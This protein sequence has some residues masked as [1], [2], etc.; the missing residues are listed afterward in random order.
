MTET[1]KDSY[2]YFWLCVLHVLIIGSLSSPVFSQEDRMVVERI[3]V[4]N[5]NL[6]VFNVFV[7]ED[8][9]KW[10]ANSKTVYKVLAKDVAEPA[11]LAPGQQSLLQLPGGN[12]D[13]RWSRD[14]MKAI[15]GDAKV[16]AAAYEKQGN[17]LWIGTDGYGVFKLSVNGGLKL[18][19]EIYVDNSKLRSDFI[20]S[21]YL[22]PDGKLWIATEDGALV[23]KKGGWDHVQRYF[24]IERIAGDRRQTWA[25]GDDL[26]WIID[27]NDNWEPIEINKREIEG[28]MHDIALDGEGNLWIASNIITRYHIG[29]GRY[30]HF[31][32]GQYFTSQFVNYV[33]VDDDGTIW[34]GTDDKGVYIIIKEST[35]TVTTNLD[36]PVSCDGDAANGA[37]SARIVGGFPPYSIAW[38]G[39]QSGDR[40]EGLSPGMYTVT[41][42]DS[43]GSSNTA[44]L[45][46][47]DPR[48]TIS[49]RQDQEESD[50]NA[51]D[52]VVSIEVDG[53]VPGYQASWSHGASGAKITGLTSG[54]YSVTVTDQAGCTAEADIQVTRTVRPLSIAIDVQTPVRCEES[55]DGIIAARAE[56]GVKPYTFRWS[57]GTDSSDVVK[58]LGPGQYA[59]TVTDK[60]G[61]SASASTTIEPPSGIKLSYAMEKAASTN[62]AD[63]VVTASASGGNPPYTYS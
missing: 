63:G 7:D 30:E 27:Q 28:F 53:G 43:K 5:Q 54:N 4:I 25:I 9:V 55:A 3:K 41:V 36:Q 2:S 19:E 26:V 52:A 14:E 33:S 22:A 51:A 12:S 46:L 34:V 13:I 60:S 44:Q 31:G 18:L 21:I 48:I 35:I 38:S 58:E 49:I 47:F 15:L 56:G 29:S 37:A 23:R 62:S 40:A 50:E 61:M 1:Y 42:T 10:V 45:E 24:N 6:P 16:T 32:P 11:D 59:V 57:T 20:N 39:G 8:N 17:V